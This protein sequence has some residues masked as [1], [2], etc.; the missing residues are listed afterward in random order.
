MSQLILL[1]LFLRSLCLGQLLFFLIWLITL[2]VQRRSLTVERSLV[3]TLLICCLGAVIFTMHYRP[4]L[5]LAARPIL[6][7][8][9][10][11]LP[12]VFW[13]YALHSLTRVEVYLQARPWLKLIPALYAFWHVA[14]FVLGQ[15]RGT[16]HEV[17]H[18]ASGLGILHII[19]LSI[20]SWRDD[21]VDARRRKRALFLIAACA[22]IMMYVISEVS[23]SRFMRSEVGSLFGALLMLSLSVSFGVNHFLHA[24]LGQPQPHTD[25]ERASPNTPPHSLPQEH[26]ALYL[27]LESFIHDQGFTQPNLTVSKL[28]SML[29]TKEYL[30]RNLIN[31]TLG[32]RN[33]SS[34]LNDQRM[35]LACDW[36]SSKPELSIT[37]I[38]LN[39]GYG[40][41]TSFNRAFKARYKM[42]PRDHRAT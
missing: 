2:T 41:I 10:D 23:G 29:D 18:L 7:A 33:F 11:G 8:L 12:I 21:L 14:Y 3:A 26:S 15:G 4:P 24:A 22:L 9:T 27:R 6:L 34:Y 42:A 1:D 30:L 17:L 37:D 40:S 13:L 39:L 20:R 32:Y 38:A 28:A 31:Q 35:P 25:T 5:A 19:F 16:V 36:L